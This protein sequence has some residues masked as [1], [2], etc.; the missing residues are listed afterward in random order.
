MNPAPAE[1][2][3]AIEDLF[4][5]ID[6]NR[7]LWQRMA[8]LLRT[9]LEFGVAQVS[10][11][12]GVDLSLVPTEAIKFLESRQN[13]IEGINATT[14]DDLK[15]S[16]MEGLAAGETLNE[17]TDRVKSVYTE[18]DQIRAEAIAN[19]ETNI[20]VNSGRFN[21]MKLAEVEKKGWRTS[22]LDGT[23]PTH[24]AAERDYSDG[25]PL[26]APFV[27][28]GE[29][30]MYPGDPKGSPGNVINCRCFTYAIL[31]KSASAPTR[32]LSYEEFIE[33]AQTPN[34]TLQEPAGEAA[35]LGPVDTH[36]NHKDQN[37]MGPRR[38]AMGS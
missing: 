7:I 29:P 35:T 24:A 21:G 10:R 19:T 25:I 8:A 12:L 1:L 2:V 27:V 38:F 34:Q 16:L 18:A 11:E 13:M 5:L 33:R 30:L 20:A 32:L 15:G 9:D 6:E 28:G 17:L 14:F 31:G 26:D 4:N 3:R 23:R 36:P 37:A 22:H